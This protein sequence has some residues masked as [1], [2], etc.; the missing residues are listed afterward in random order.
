MI[1]EKEFLKLVKAE[2]QKKKSRNPRFSIRQYAKKLELSIGALSELL[3]GKRR[4]TRARALK[5]VECL[6]LTED[7]KNRLFVL[8]GET[9]VG[10]AAAASSPENIQTMQEI[11]TDWRNFVILSVLFHADDEKS[12]PRVAKATCLTEDEVRQRLTDLRTKL[13]SETDFINLLID[14]L[15]PQSQFFAGDS[16]TQFRESQLQMMH[17]K[18]AQAPNTSDAFFYNLPLFTSQERYEKISQEIRQVLLKYLTVEPEEHSEALF[19][20]SMQILP[21]DCPKTN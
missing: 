9:Q 13:P 4:L 5:I 6:E 14:P 7:E 8:M 15:Q 19:Q 11:I 20:I 3:A 17:K 16:L 18:M 2:F 10:T 1:W 21:L 12:I